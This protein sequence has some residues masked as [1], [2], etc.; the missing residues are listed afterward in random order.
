MSP[1][2]EN[3]P[4]LRSPNVEAGNSRRID[5]VMREPTLIHSVETVAD[6]FSPVHRLDNNSSNNQ[7][8]NQGSNQQIIGS[9][10]IAVCVTNTEDNRA[11]MSGGDSISTANNTTTAVST[12]NTFFGIDMPF[13]VVSAGYATLVAAGGLIG[14]L[15]AGS[16]P[17]LVAGL[18]FGSV[19]GVGAYMTSVDPDNYYLTM[20]TSAILGSFMGYRF[21]NSGKFMPAGLITL[22]SI[23]MIARFSVR[24]FTQIKHHQK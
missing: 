11:V 23:G 13:D 24:A 6:H 18:G 4:A 5:E 17:S 7:A 16:I 15:K 8:G 19:L 9:D 20:G 12:Y 10:T 3:V 22:L 21:L 2:E 1:K 14:Y